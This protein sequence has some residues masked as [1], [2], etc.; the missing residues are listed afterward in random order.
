[1]KKSVLFIIASLLS[2]SLFGKEF[3]FVVVPDVQKYV[4]TETNKKDYP[5]NSMQI[6]KNEMQWIADNSTLNNGNISFALFVGDM[7]ERNYKKIEWDRSIEAVSILN[8]KIPFV[9]AAGNHDTDHLN[10][11]TYPWQVNG[12]KRFSKNFGPDSELMKNKE[13]YK[14]TFSESNSIA[15]FDAGNTKI[16]VATIEIQPTDEALAWLDEMLTKYSDYPTIINTHEYL[17]PYVINDKVEGILEYKYLEKKNNVDNSPKDMFEKVLSKHDQVFFICNGHYTGSFNGERVC[18][19]SL[20]QK[21]A[22]NNSVY[23][24]HTDYE[25]R[26]ELLNPY[27][28][29]KKVGCGDG[30]IRIVTIDT[31]KNTMKLQTYSTELNR[32]E[33]DADSEIN[34]NFDFNWNKRFGAK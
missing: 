3:S 17:F 21:N 34:I 8:N 28:M 18:E 26:H 6:Y 11:W 27:E 14:E 31:D 24:F 15:L 33:T 23:A 7:V 4:Y 2:I 25:T 13:W 30:W 10:K 9:V 19:S 29:K 5:I 20:L 16:C 12:F 22:Y 1:M 32:Y